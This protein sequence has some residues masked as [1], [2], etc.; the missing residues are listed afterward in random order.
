MKLHSYLLTSLVLTIACGDQKTVAEAG[1][2]AA[3]AP[4]TS[5][6]IKDNSVTIPPGARR[7]G[8]PLAT[9]TSGLALVDRLDVADEPDELR[10]LY[11]IQEPTF[12]GVRDFDLGPKRGVYSDHGRAA[13]K[14]ESFRFRVIPQQDHLLVKAFDATAKGQKVRVVIDGEYV[15]DWALPDGDTGQY[16]EAAFP[17][18]GSFIGARTKLDIQLEPVSGS[19]DM[20]AYLYWLFG[21]PDRVLQEPVSTDVV[22]L[23]LIDRLD[24]GGTE[25]ESAHQYSVT[26]ETNSGIRELWWPSSGLPFLETGRANKASESFRM[27][28]EPGRDHLLVKA[29]DT[30]SK[31]QIL[32][33]F[34]D[35]SPVGDWNLPNLASRYGEGSYRIPAKIIGNKKVIDIRV[36]FVA[37]S[38]DVN[39]L[40]YWLFAAPT[41]QRG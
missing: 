34:V 32:R 22:G 8:R 31:D 40:K 10:H 18:Q 36:E 9:D 15:G 12:L 33:V 19:P 23:A 37:A 1:P 2:T 38:N 41:E 4:P 39:S 26:N 30:L 7:L 5:E 13:K 6:P 11:R 16:G 21:K 20:N 35:G 24:V 27:K 28:V 17:I 14:G 29:Y 25:D 3:A